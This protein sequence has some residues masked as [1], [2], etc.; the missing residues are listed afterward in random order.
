MLTAI[1]DTKEKE[2]WNSEYK[3]GVHWEEGHSK[4]AEEF[5]EMLKTGNLLLDAGCGSGRDSIFFAE[6]GFN[7]TGV[8]ISEEAI[9]KARE[10]AEKQ[11]VK[12][13]FEVMNVE[14]LPY[15]DETFDAVYSNAVLHFTG[16]KESGAEIYRILKKNGIAFI[17]IILSTTDM[18]TNEIKGKGSVERIMSAFGRFRVLEQKEI[19][20]IDGKPEPHK[21]KILVLV[22]KKE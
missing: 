4:G 19:E 22:M 16:L 2:R 1:D 13:R 6:S 9:K 7:V 8:D 3:K 18:R 12:I 10:S 11:N 17:T 15:K 20:K 14:K 21:H 5:A